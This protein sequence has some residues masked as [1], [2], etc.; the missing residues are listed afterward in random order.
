M[1]QFIGQIVESRVAIYLVVGG[2]KK[3]FGIF[4]R[5]M[6]MNGLDHPNADAF[7]AAGIDIAGVFNRHLRIGGMEAANVLVAQPLFGADE[8]FPKWPVFHGRM[9]YKG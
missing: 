6:N 7:I 2:I 8:Y 3:R 5:S 1:P 9:N 4:G